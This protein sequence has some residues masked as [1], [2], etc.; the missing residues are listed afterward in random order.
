MKKW[1]RNQYT[2]GKYQAFIE[3]YYDQLNGNFN[4]FAD[5]KDGEK[6]EKKLDE[7]FRTIRAQSDRR[8]YMKK[9][10]AIN[11]DGVTEHWRLQVESLRKSL[12]EAEKEAAKAEEMDKK[13]AEEAAKKE[14]EEA[15]KEKVRRAERVKEA[16]A[17]L[18]ALERGEPA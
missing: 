18:D 4:L 17:T 10:A 9:K 6:E 12:A 7:R 16:R 8:A 14:K 11:K 5:G 15:E 3:D 1:F 13:L 2:D